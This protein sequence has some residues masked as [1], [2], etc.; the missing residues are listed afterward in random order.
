MEVVD[1]PEPGPPAPGQVVV[2]PEAIGI[3]GSDFHYFHGDLGSVGD[4]RA[5][6][7]YPGP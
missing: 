3:C 1:V 7:A 5:L 6:P 2:R 4:E